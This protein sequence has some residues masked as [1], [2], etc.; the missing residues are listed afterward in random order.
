MCFTRY[1]VVVLLDRDY[2]IINSSTTYNTV[3]GNA[4]YLAIRKKKNEKIEM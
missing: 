2:F 3:P 4:P 1:S